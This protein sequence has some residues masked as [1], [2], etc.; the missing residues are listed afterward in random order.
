MAPEV[1][2]A[3]LPGLA[4]EEDEVGRALSPVG[5][6]MRNTPHCR[7]RAYAGPTEKDYSP[8]GDIK[9]EGHIWTRRIAHKDK[10]LDD[11]I[12]QRSARTFGSKPPDVREG[13][14]RFRGRRDRP[15][16]VGGGGV[17]EALG[18]ALAAFASAGGALAAFAT[19]G[20]ALARAAR[21][22]S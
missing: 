13:I 18:L 6:A 7:G 2:L 22:A 9:S 3:P 4:V 19:S 20:L 14:H 21:A 10:A 11:A 8:T 1:P 12:W 5:G 16:P 15:S 17:C